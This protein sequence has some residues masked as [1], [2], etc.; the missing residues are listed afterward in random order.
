MPSERVT[1]LDIN[2]SKCVLWCVI[3]VKNRSL[4]SVKMKKKKKFLL[5]HCIGSCIQG[6]NI[7]FV[8]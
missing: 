8:W 4:I 7:T 2:S 3:V 1:I 5:Y 6:V